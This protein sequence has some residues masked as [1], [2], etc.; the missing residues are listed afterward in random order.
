ML[1]ITPSTC[2]WIIVNYEKTLDL[3][4]HKRG[5]VATKLGK[6]E[7]HSS[8]HALWLVPACTHCGWFSRQP[9]WHEAAVR[10]SAFPS[11]GFNHAQFL[12]ILVQVHNLHRHMGRPVGEH[13][14][15][16]KSPALSKWREWGL[17]LPHGIP[18]PTSHPGFLPT[19]SQ[20]C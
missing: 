5:A 1:S 14:Y 18:S 10:P 13:A 7:I 9:H 6:P 17:H 11:N 16:A 15:S 20:P 4:G 3:W 8:L 2:F 19:V 12:Q